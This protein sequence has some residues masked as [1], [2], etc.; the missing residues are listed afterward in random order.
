MTCFIL[1]HVHCQ[2]RC[3]PCVRVAIYKSTPFKIKDL[4]FRRRWALPPATEGSR[5]V[6]SQ[7]HIGLQR[8]FLDSTAYTAL[9]ATPLAVFGQLEHWPWLFSM[10]SASLEKPRCHV[11]KCS[12]KLIW[13]NDNVVNQ[14]IP[15]PES[16]DWKKNGD[17]H[18]QPVVNTL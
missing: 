8:A 13:N 14:T 9:I 3:I 10:Y 1:L 16:Y 4:K 2:P 5:G 6:P 15:Y 17:S 18:W 12:V 11:D 7:R